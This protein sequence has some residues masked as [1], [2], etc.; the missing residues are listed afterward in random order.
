MDIV[1]RLVH[2]CLSLLH[3][4]HNMHTVEGDTN[5]SVGLRTAEH[6]RLLVTCGVKMAAYN[7]LRA[8]FEKIEN[9]S[10]DNQIDK[11]SLRIALQQALNKI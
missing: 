5:V 6:V 7:E 4:E 8:L 1:Y 10:S 2:T 3:V 11:N 9:S